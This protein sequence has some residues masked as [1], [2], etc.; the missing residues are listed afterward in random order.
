MQE[1]DI[2][3][4]VKESESETKME[5]KAPKVKFANEKLV[6]LIEHRSELNTDTKSNTWYTSDECH[7]MAKKAGIEILVQSKGYGNTPRRDDDSIP[8]STRQETRGLEQY[9]SISHYKTF[10]NARRDRIKA[11]LDA[12][13]AL[14][15]FGVKDHSWAI[16]IAC[17]RESVSSAM[18]ASVLGLSDQAAAFEIYREG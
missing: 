1:D 3:L 6:Y 7:A 5:K 12:Q 8:C 16:H 14:R 9:L 10:K 2:S 4:N 11:V 18:K 13:R 15:S 17:A